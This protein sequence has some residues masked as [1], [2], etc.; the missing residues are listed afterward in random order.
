MNRRPHA[1]LILLLILVIVAPLSVVIAS[2]PPRAERALRASRVAQAATTGSLP[3]DLLSP[4][5]KTRWDLSGLTLKPSMRQSFTPTVDGIEVIHGQRRAVYRDLDEP[6]AVS[7]WLLPDRDSG[8]LQPG[9]REVLE[10]IEQHGESEDRL[11]IE[12]VVVGIGWV[13]LPSGPHEAILQ[14]ALVLREPDGERGYSPERLVHRWID[15]RAGVVAEVSG[16]AS[17]DG[18]TRLGIEDVWVLEQMMFGAGTLKIYVDELDDGPYKGIAYGWD[19]GAGTTVSS[20]VPDPN[21]S[22]IGQLLAL[23][24]WNFSGNTTGVERASTTVPVDPN[25]TCNTSQCGYSFPGA[26][27]DREDKNWEAADPNN[28]DR[29]NTV[30][31]REVRPGD[32]T[33]WLR[34]GAQH[35][36]KTG[37][38]GSGESRFCYV[39]DGTG[40][41]T[42]APLWRF[43]HQDAIDPNRWYM[44]AGDPPWSGGP[45]GSCQQVLFNEV[46]GGGG[47]FSH[48]YAKSCTGHTG[49]QGGAV[50]KAGVVTVP[51]G[52]TFN[53]LV[54]SNI[55]DFCVYPGASCVLKADEVKTVNYLWQVPILG[56]VVRLQSA[57]NVPDPNGFT[58]LAET[59]FKF[60]LFPPRSITVT[61][62][63]DTTISLSWDPGLDTHRITGYRVYWDTDSGAGSSYAFNSQANPGQAV[64]AGTTATISGLTPG[65]SYYFTVTSRTS[66]TDPSSHITTAYESLLYPTQVSGDPAFVYPTEVTAPTTGGVC[67]PGAEVTNLTLS[68]SPGGGVQFCWDPLSDP[69]VIGYRILASNVPNPVGGFGKLVDVGLSTCWIGDP[70]VGVFLVKARGNGGVGP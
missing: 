9:T 24:N 15:P 10:L 69:C 62:A 14:R 7:R 22:T 26:E 55:A 59:D 18:R 70:P 58:T 35:E 53:A 49:T 50:I 57:Q 68:H 41:R 66:F 31:Q 64:I 61:G 63:T 34:A 6:G 23:N 42:P 5:G 65:T 13:H 48:L 47:T 29:I 37:S 38:L 67:V 20:L 28:V 8:L 46:C 25:E 36:G 43:S 17:G 1:L 30:T 12:T 51:S 56:T 19:K 54:I 3:A 16:P 11:R 27:L 21:I 52:H 45:G 2:D 44:Q 4:E 32:L 60:G 40:T 39:T 33:I